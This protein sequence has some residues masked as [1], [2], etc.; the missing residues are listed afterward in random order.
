MSTFP[1]TAQRE[2]ERFYRAHESVSFMSP[3]ERVRTFNAAVEPLRATLRA[4]YA[5]K[6]DAGLANLTAAQEMIERRRYDSFE[7]EPIPGATFTEAE[8]ELEVLL[9][10]QINE[11]AARILGGVVRSN[12]D[13]AASAAA[14]AL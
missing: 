2:E 5:A 13:A 4:L 11:T 14:A 12:Y 3:A 7:R 8:R 9:L 6:R 10:R 1:E